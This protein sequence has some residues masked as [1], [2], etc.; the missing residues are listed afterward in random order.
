VVAADLE[1]DLILI[2]ET[3]CNSTIS[4]AFLRIK[5][6]EIQQDLRKDRNDTPDGRGGGLLV[7]SK[8]G[9][10]ILS[11][12]VDNTF[13]QYCK[14]DVHDTTLY[15]VYRP[16]NSTQQNMDKL[17]ELISSTMENTIMIG[18]FNLP[19][20]DWESGAASPCERRVV[21]AVH[22]KLMEQ[23]VSFNTHLKGNT[24]DLVLTNIPERITEIR[25]EGRLGQSDHAMMVIE[26]SVNAREQ[27]S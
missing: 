18:D 2:T 21:E 11:G 6:Y 20:V 1:P 26:V 16:P 24:L 8:Q 22:D 13:N 4:E 25:E 17:A 5:G 19:G 12:D 27:V 3:W 14:F 15:L 23:M 10:K 9:L 7:Y